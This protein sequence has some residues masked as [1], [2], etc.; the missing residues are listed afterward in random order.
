[1]SGGSR[2][3]GEDHTACRGAGAIHDPDASR[4][5]EVVRA[6]PLDYNAGR[7]G[8]R[9]VDVGLVGRLGS[10]KTTVF[11][12]LTGQDAAM[13]R[14]G[15]GRTE[16]HQALA[17]I[18]DE[19]LEV[20]REMFHPRKLTPAQL[21]VV[22]VPGLQRGDADG[23]N[24]F[25]NEVRQVDALVH[26]VRGFPDALGAAPDPVAEADDMAL[27]LALSDLNL[28]ERRLERLRAG[29]QTAD[30]RREAELVARLAA[31]LE[32]GGRLD[33]AELSE[34]E[35]RWLS[36]YQFLTLKPLIWVVNLDE[37]SFQRQ[38]FPGREELERL[39]AAKGV[40]VLLMAG[41]WEMEVMRLADAERAEFLAELGLRETGISRLARTVY[42]HLGLI[43]FLTAG[44]DEVRA[45]TI[46][47]GTTAKVAAGKIHS[48]IE[49]GFIRAEV[50]AF[51]DLAAAGSLA[52][53]RERGLVRMEGKDYVMAD[54]DV[55]NFRF[56]V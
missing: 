24:R 38:E 48:D 18:P 15:G 30:A 25:L 47:A 44:E 36:G 51:Q 52:R 31:V 55:V 2:A 43:S 28:L 5:S 13:S 41:R 1:L 4:P 11:N 23:P 22:D 34:E 40:P 16:S 29:K 10:G 53:A 7:Q 50:V 32:G 26:V 9:T 39:A 56:N 37:D 42:R 49:R 21:R 17:P 46:A 12:L 35:E 3:G 54:G 27:E 33:Q 14:F 6:D 19:R 20:L 8:D 45:W